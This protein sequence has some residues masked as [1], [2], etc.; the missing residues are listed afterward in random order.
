MLVRAVTAYA[1]YMLAAD[2]KVLSWNAGAERLKG[3]TEPEI[4]GQHFSTFFAAEDRAAGKP[5]AALKTAAE[6]GRA[7]EEG[8]LVRK[9]GSR[10]W[11]L[12]TIDAIRY[13]DV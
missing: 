7:E 5:A 4:I 3:Y 13:A 8:C 1:I 12:F 11:G 10:F 9:D 2:G 6:T